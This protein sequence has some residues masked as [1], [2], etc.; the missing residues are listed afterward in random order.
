VILEGL[1]LDEKQ[2][3]VIVL[4]ALS[5][6]ARETIN[7]AL[8]PSSPSGNTPSSLCLTPDGQIHTGST[9]PGLLDASDGA[10][11]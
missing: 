1:P 8:Y 2:E 10:P 11:P 9:M 6:K 7:C 3:P 5:G 4:D